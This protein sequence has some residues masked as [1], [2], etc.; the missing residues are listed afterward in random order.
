MDF[1]STIEF[2]VIAITL[3]IIIASAALN[4]KPENKCYT[5][6]YGGELTPTESID[7][8]EYISIAPSQGNKIVLIHHNALLPDEC[9]NV[10]IRVDVS[11]D[12]IS[13]IEKSVY[14]SGLFLKKVQRYDIAFS[15]GC[16]KNITY[17]MKYECEYGG[18]WCNISFNNI[19]DYYITKDIKL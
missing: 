18:K 16:L 11:G 9:E 15:I 7:E 14:G 12:N 19:G 1:F 6:I 10:N 8:N 17:Y 4:K 13:C 5:Y 2:Y 3:A